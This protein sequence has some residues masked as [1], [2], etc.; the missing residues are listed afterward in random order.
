MHESLIPYVETV[1]DLKAFI[2]DIPEDYAVMIE[3]DVED[4]D[5]TI[6]IDGDEMDLSYSMSM[7]Y[8]PKRKIFFVLRNY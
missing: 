1:G 8:D 7:G 6:T 5:M 4:P 3:S 2:E